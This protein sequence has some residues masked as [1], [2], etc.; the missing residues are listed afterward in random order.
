MTVFWGF[1]LS[2][3]GGSIP[4]TIWQVNM[5]YS[6]SPEDE[7][8]QPVDRFGFGPQAVGSV[9]LAEAYFVADEYLCVLPPSGARKEE[10]KQT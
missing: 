9:V 8:T 5:N 6:C 2:Y 1:D 10:K 7:S 3:R 4:A